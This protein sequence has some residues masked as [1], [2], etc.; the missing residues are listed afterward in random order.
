MNLRSFGVPTVVKHAWGAIAC[1]ADEVKSLG[2]QRPLLVVGQGL[3]RS[4]IVDEATRLLKAGGIDYVLFD[5]VVEN[6]PI[7]VVDAG[8]ALYQ[9]AGCD[10]IIG[11]GGGSS[12]DTAKA[13]GVVVTHSGSI[14]AYEWADPN[15]I[16]QP[17]PPLIAIPTTAGTG[18]EVTLWSVITD[19]ARRIKYNVGGT[20]LIGPQVALIDPALTVSLPAPLTAGTGM[21]ALAHAIECY[22]CAYA[23]AWPDAV[24][25]Q[26][27]EYV[28]D[29]LRIAY[30]QGH[31]QTARYKMAM[32][33]MLGGMAYGTESAGAAHAMSQTAGGVHDTVPHGALTAWLLGPVMEYNY[34]GEPHKFAR[35]AQALGQDTRGLSIWQAAEK[36]VEAVYQLIKDLQIPSLQ[37]LGFTEAEIPLLADLAA[38]D[39]QTIGNPRDIDYDGYVQLYTRA[40][41]LGAKTSG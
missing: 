39:P 24:A 6:P 27:M 26:A 17:I 32:A 28:N 13:I 29:Y 22:T 19:P 40:F 14:R 20:F 36:A 18:S 5:Q 11:L 34:L 31:N 15:P 10:G 41:A 7:A 23:Q 12:M 3:L 1:L 30:A 2:V 37:Q 16:V 35:I 33:A 38:K 25:L 9:Q 8:A 21:D 4:G